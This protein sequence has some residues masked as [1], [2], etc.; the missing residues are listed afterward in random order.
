MVHIHGAGKMVDLMLQNA[1]VPAT[2]FNDFRLS[3]FV[4]TFHAHA[5]RTRRE[6]H[7]VFQAKA[8]FKIFNALFAKKRDSRID[9]DVKWYR[10]ALAV[11][12]LLRRPVFDVFGTVLNHRQLNALSDLRRG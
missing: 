1:R 12:Q 2:G 5:A 3:S 9:D 7:Q 11:G 8:T 10:L 4:H 6:R